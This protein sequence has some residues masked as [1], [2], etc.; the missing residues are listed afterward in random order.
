MSLSRKI[1]KAGAINVI[2]LGERGPAS[3]TKTDY[4]QGNSQLRPKAESPPAPVEAQP[5]AGEEADRQ[6]SEDAY[7]KGIDEGMKRGIEEAK[8]TLDPVLV[9]LEKAALKISELKDSLWRQSE[10][11]MIDLVFAIVEKIIRRDA[12]LDRTIVREL[13]EEILSGFNNNEDVVVRLN[14]LDYQVLKS[15]APDYL[16]DNTQRVN[17]RIEED[18]RIEPGGAVVETKS[19]VID[20][21]I[22]E[23]LQSLRDAI[24]LSYG[25]VDR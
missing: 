25:P 24:T 22:E 11:S 16:G 19:L 20:A 13:L 18:R 17:L 6:R 1:I 23:Q 21:R 14:P 7:K 3:F 2:P 4:Q 8:K 5:I 15:E 12:S 10:E 9:T